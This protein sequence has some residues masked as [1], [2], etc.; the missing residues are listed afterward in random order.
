MRRC[1]ACVLLLA[2]S[3]AGA[4]SATTLSLPEPGYLVI[5]GQYFGYGLRPP[6][7]SSGSALLSALGAEGFHFHTVLELGQCSRANGTAPSLPDGA[8]RFR[9]ADSELPPNLPGLA[10]AAA[11]PG[12]AVRVDLVAC[13]GATVLLLRSADGDLS[14]TG[15][16]RFPLQRGACPAL[17]AADPGHVYFSSFE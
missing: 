8:A 10:F 6:P 1:G 17:D 3:L 11:E 16:L 9:S 14:C 4:A 15:A 2:A 5:D 12:A 7:A 13:A